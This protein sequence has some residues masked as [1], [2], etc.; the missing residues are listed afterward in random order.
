MSHYTR[1]TAA[2][3]NAYAA[4]YRELGPSCG[5]H[6]SMTYG[7]LPR[8]TD[9]ARAFRAVCPDGTFSFGNDPFVGFAKLEADDLWLQLES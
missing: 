6:T 4:Q 2:Q 7:Q 1:P 9:Y 3:I 8:P 5:H